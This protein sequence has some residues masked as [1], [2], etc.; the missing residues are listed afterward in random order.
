MTTITTKRQKERGAPLFLP[1][2]QETL[3]PTPTRAITTN[4]EGHCRTRPPHQVQSRGA[5]MMAPGR[6][7]YLVITGPRWLLT[8]DRRLGKT[9]S[10][11]VLYLVDS[12]ETSRLRMGGKSFNPTA[13]DWDRPSVPRF[14]SKQG[15]GVGEGQERARRRMVSFCARGSEE[16][17]WRGRSSYIFS[18]KSRR[19]DVVGNGHVSQFVLG[20]W[21][22]GRGGGVLVLYLMLSARAGSPRLTWVDLKP[23][24]LPVG[25]SYPSHRDAY[26]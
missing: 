25:S 3:C 8:E 18:G 4:N 17:T 5:M 16:R 14:Q 10:S 19:E 21:K 1:Q 9:D 26:E 2:G 12:P 13:H 22:E 20:A 15:R 7:K 6:N 24:R 23:I 11:L